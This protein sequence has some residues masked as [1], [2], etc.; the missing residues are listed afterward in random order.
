MVTAGSLRGRPKAVKKIFPRKIS[1]CSGTCHTGGMGVSAPVFVS[2]PARTLKQ[3]GPRTLTVP[4]ASSLP[5]YLPGTEG[6]IPCH[7]DAS[8]PGIVRKENRKN[9]KIT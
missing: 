2:S 7:P 5:N 3:M 6:I 1:G 9:K 8:G 4:A